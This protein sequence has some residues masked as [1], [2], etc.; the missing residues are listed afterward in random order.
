MAFFTRKRFWQLHSVA[1]LVAGL[2]LLVIGLSGTALLFHE[3]LQALVAPEKVRVIP[4]AEGK[5]SLQARVAALEAALP[6]HAVTGWDL[7]HDRRDAAEGAYVM[8]FGTREWHYVTVDP[9]RGTL[10]SSPA[11]HDSTLKGWL[12]ELHYTLLMGDW[13]LA[14]A[15]LLAVLWLFLGGSGFVLYRRFWATLFRLRW[16]ESLRLLVGDFHRLVGV[17]SCV[18]ATL[19]GFTGAYWNLEHTW[20]HLQGEPVDPMDQ[21]IFHEKL[22]SP[23][24]RLDDLLLDAEKRIPGFRADY[25]SLPWAPGGP[26]TLWGKSVHAGW[27]QSAHGSQVGYDG[28]S[29]VFVHAHDVTKDSW[30]KQIEDSFEPLHFGAFGGWPVRILWAFAG[31]APALLALSGTWI[32]WQRRRGRGT[33]GPDPRLRESSE[34]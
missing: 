5:L 20:E 33:Q 23:S 8:P 25:V 3:E 18:M 6:Q 21:A 16:R 17:T 7:R 19:L 10:L 31:L 14:L 26:V 29:G 11:H 28:K 24:L 12:L 15:G 4:T 27:W 13:G 1:G 9:Y 22:L 32:W 2:G 30:W 34:T